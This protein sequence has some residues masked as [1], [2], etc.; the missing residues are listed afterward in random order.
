VPEQGQQLLYESERWTV[1]LGRR[2]LLARRVPVPLGGRAFEIIEV[3]V[4]S[5]GEVV[6]K[7]ELMERVWPG[8][9]VEEN[10]LQVHI[11]AVRK[12]LGSDRGLLKT[13][14][15]RGYRLI[16]DWTSREALRQASVV[17]VTPAALPGRPFKTNLPLAVSKLIGRTAA[18]KQ[19]L[20]LMSAYRVVT[21]T[22]PGGI[23]KTSLA[24][25]VAR[26]LLPGIDGDSWV[27]E[28]ASLSDPDLVC[29]TVAGV[30]GLEL[31]GHAVS[32][33]S[34]AQAIGGRQMLLV[35]DNCEHVIDIAA[36]LTE[37]IV[38]TCPRTSV[39]A[40][41]REA[42]RIDSEVS[43]RVQPLDVPSGNSEVAN[44]LLRHSAV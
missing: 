43:Y 4:K 22:G 20:D 1:D 5:A 32:P 10:T 9:I 13:V 38:R 40:T 19:L 29:S 23:G 24:L 37:A 44:D 35:L 25:E 12:A 26:S 36:R 16:G 31:G 7:D 27:V 2:E 6:S 34:I 21:L 3:L 39:L 28:L 33:A 8:A 42:L 17:G 11:S 41:S 14:S 30:L 18:V 15:G